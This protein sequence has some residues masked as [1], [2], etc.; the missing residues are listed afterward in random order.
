M[1]SINLN[2]ESPLV[3]ISYAKEDKLFA[4][5]IYR[6]MK[7][8]NLKPWL[9]IHHLPVGV[10]WDNFIKETIKNSK[11]FILILSKNSTNKRGYIQKE[12]KIALEIVELLPQEDIFIIPIKIDD[13]I[14]PQVLGK[15]Q[16][17]DISKRDYY[18]KIKKDIISYLGDSYQASTKYKKLADKNDYTY[19]N[20][21]LRFI[22]ESGEF[23]VCKDFEKNKIGISNTH[24]LE[25]VDANDLEKYKIEYRNF[26]KDKFKSVIPKVSDYKNDNY[27]LAKMVTKDKT[28]YILEANNG[29]KCR[30]SITYVNYFMKKYYPLKIYIWSEDY[31]KPII[32]ESKGNIVGLIM[33]KLF[34][35]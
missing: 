35:Y 31:V 14:P 29:N 33:P 13:C 8:D 1:N 7:R 23:I 30:A 28:D 2:I 4:E 25:I 16:W 34:E 27:E 5:N 19:D 9:D 12:I 22:E 6:K 21:F 18:S 20:E 26:S 24:I 11:F 32:C 3:F 17:I 10:N 15:F